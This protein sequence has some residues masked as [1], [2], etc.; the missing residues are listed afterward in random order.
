MKTTVNFTEFCDRFAAMDRN[1][2]FTYSGKRALFD[3]LE[4]CERGMGEEI[5][6]DVIALCCEW[7]EY[8]TAFEAAME[9]GYDDEPQ[10][11]LE[12]LNDHTTVIEFDGGVIIQNY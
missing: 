6:L 2:N 4:D 5:E 11:P 1:E 8:A 9:Y 7:R 10:T 12:F 3:Y